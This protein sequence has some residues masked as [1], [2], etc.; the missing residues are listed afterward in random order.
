MELNEKIKYWVDIAEYDLETAGAMLETK[1]LLYVGFMCHQ[2]VE[3]I[4]KGYYQFKKNTIPPYTHD[5]ER[6][7]SEALIW[8]S[9][10]DDHK[11]LIYVLQP[12]NIQARYPGYKDKIFS[13]LDYDRCKE[14]VVQTKELFKW[15]KTQ[16]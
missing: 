10:S 13:S 14:L 5:L 12:F 11:N 4:L 9:L 3:K 16:L 1:R 7:A 6:L 2:A 15:I 8:D